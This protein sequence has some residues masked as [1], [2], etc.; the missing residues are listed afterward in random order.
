MGNPSSRFDTISCSCH[1][2]DEITFHRIPGEENQVVV[3]L[4]TLSSMY[5]VN[6]HNKESVMIMDLE[7]SRYIVNQLKRNPM[8]N[9]SFIYIKCYLQKQEYPT[10]ASNGDKRTLW[11]L[12]S[13]FFLNGEMFYKRKYDMVLLRCMDKHEVDMLNKEIRK[14]SFGCVK[15]GGD[16]LV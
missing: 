3:A 2:T 13:K 8:V 12:L 11:R 14:G 15:L 9:H 1:I 7:M 6:F 10:N 16:R 4:A 5:K